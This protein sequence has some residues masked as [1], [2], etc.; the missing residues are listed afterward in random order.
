MDKVY[1]LLPWLSIEQAL[2]WLRDMTCTQLTEKELLQLCDAG[3]CDVYLDCDNW[4]GCLFDDGD[5]FDKPPIPLVGNGFCRAVYPLEISHKDGFAITVIGSAR[6]SD[7]HGEILEREWLADSI[8]GRHPEPMFKSSDIQLLADKMNGTPDRHADI[9][10]LHQQLEQ[11]RAA[12]KAAEAEL[13]ELRAK[14]D[15]M[16]KQLSEYHANSQVQ[17]K[18][19]ASVGLTFPYVTKDLEVM[20]DAALKF[21]ANHTPDKRQPS[22]KEVGLMIGEMLGLKVQASGEPARKAQHLASLIKPD[23]LPDGT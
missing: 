14:I 10:V 19:S 13:L 11:E 5:P 15:R 20:R 4:N 9:E 7:R 8:Y 12:R 22:Q 2:T 21:W 6:R 23:V 1:R 3:Q 17:A 18:P 16:A